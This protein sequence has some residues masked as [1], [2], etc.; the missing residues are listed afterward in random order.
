MDI[1]MDLEKNSL[2]KYEQELIGKGIWF[3]WGAPFEEEI[4]MTTAKEQ[5]MENE[6]W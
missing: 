1:C 4:G 5:K 3:F 6:V 2:K